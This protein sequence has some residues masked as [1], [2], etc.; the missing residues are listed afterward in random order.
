MAVRFPSRSGANNRGHVLTTTFKIHGRRFLTVNVKIKAF[1]IRTKA[2]ARFPAGKTRIQCFSKIL[3]ARVAA[4]R[5]NATI[6]VHG[7]L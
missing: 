7:Q 1:L 4:T 6:I 2:Q 5:R 3:I